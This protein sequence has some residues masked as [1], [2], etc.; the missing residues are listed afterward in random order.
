VLDRGS[1]ARSQRQLPGNASVVRSFVT[2][3]G[4]AWPSGHLELLRRSGVTV[5]TA[6]PRL[7]RSVHARSSNLVM[8]VPSSD[9]DAVGRRNTW[10]AYW[11]D[12][13]NRPYWERP[14]PDF[15]SWLAALGRPSDGHALDLG[16]GIGR[17]IPCLL[18]RGFRVTAVDSSAQALQGAA[19]RAATLSPSPS[20]RLGD[21]QDDLFAPSTFDLVLAFNVI[22]HGTKASMKAAIQNVHR[23]LK[24]GGLLY[25]TCPSRRDGKCG[26]GEFVEPNTYRPDNSVHAG[27][28]HYF[29]D[30]E[31]L[32]QLLV[33]YR[34]RLRDLK[35][36]YWDN[37][38][39]RQFSSHW[40]IAAERLETLD[41]ESGE[42]LAG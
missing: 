33:G 3:G 40:R 20:F 32:E 31:A 8:P 6:R 30:A 7:D 23:W 13:A 37:A 24:P 9:P 22:Y 19:L 10:D 1:P 18:D 34:I 35:E 36:H 41:S 14:D 38:G 2:D 28:V 21:Y 4:A 16:C 27:D 5:A 12:Q 26:R 15:A 29:A 17:H 25:F 11:A 39:H 42:T